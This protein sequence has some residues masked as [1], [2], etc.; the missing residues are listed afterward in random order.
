MNK[1]TLIVIIVLM[2]VVAGCC[3]D[4]EPTESD[5][6]TSYISF[7]DKGAVSPDAISI[8]TKIDKDYILTTSYQRGSVISSWNNRLLSEEYDRLN[9]II[10]NNNL[11]GAPDPVDTIESHLCIGVQGIEIVI[12]TES[13]IDTINIEGIYRCDK[14]SWPIGLDSI[15]LYKES[16]VSKYGPK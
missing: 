2:V 13:I 3:K 16:L 9:S 12:K 14:S 5:T 11:I 7:L 1:I 6:T 4:P 15:L 8:L 10:M